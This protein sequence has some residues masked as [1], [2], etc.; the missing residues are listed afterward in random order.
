MKNRKKRENAIEVQSFCEG[1]YKLGDNYNNFE[2]IF[3]R[4]IE[5]KSIKR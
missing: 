2:W 1:E 4:K 3:D 5:E